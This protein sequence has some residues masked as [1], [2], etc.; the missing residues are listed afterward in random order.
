MALDVP[1]PKGPMWVLGDVFI[2]KYY[3]VFDRDKE[4]VGFAKA[5]KL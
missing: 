1:E 5:K 3:T 2:R 4:R